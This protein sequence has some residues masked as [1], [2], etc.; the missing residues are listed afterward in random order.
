[1]KRKGDVPPVRAR[2]VGRLAD[3]AEKGCAGTRGKTT[4]RQQ[5]QKLYGIHLV[6]G[7]AG[8][9]HGDGAISAALRGNAKRWMLPFARR[10]SQCLAHHAGDRRPMAVPSAG[11]TGW[12]IMATGLAGG[13]TKP[14]KGIR[15]AALTRPELPT[16][17]PVP[18]DAT[19]SSSLRSLPQVF[20]N[21]S[22]VCW[23]RV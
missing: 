21:S 2:T 18:L 9:A 3:A 15:P 16:H 13:L 14:C 7:L 8:A 17:A 4:R 10:I 12:A 11:A 1:M 6:P 5:R 23:K 20:L 19:Q 22:P